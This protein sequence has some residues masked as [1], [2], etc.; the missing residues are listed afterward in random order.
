MGLGGRRGL[1]PG[2]PRAPLPAPRRGSER[3]GGPVGARA[4]WGGQCQRGLPGG[5]QRRFCASLAGLPP[6]GQRPRRCCSPATGRGI[7]QGRLFGGGEEETFG[8]SWLLSAL[9]QSCRAPSSRVSPQPGTCLL[10]LFPFPPCKWGGAGG[11]GARARGPGGSS[12]VPCGW[13]AAGR[14]GSRG[15]GTGDRG[16]LVPRG[17]VGDGDGLVFTTHQQFRPPPP[18][19]PPARCWGLAPLGAAGGTRRPAS[20]MV[21]K[22]LALL[23]GVGSSGF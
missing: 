22:G 18:L 23:R 10:G 13:V 14:A 12:P 3:A 19:G 7:G 17:A 11:H 8:R 21:G 16:S 5:G 1:P 4:A 2:S 6:P 15:R 20:P 9:L